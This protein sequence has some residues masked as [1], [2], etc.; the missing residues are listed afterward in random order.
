MQR[1][2]DLCKKILHTRDDTLSNFVIVE[3][4][5][6][7]AMA[8]VLEALA[9]YVQNMLTN[10]AKEE[11]HML[12]GVPYEMKKMD[13]KLRDLKSFLA[14]ADM[15][16]ISDETVQ[17]WVKEFR[18]AMYD[19][20]DILDLCQ[21]KSMKQGPSRDGIGCFDPLLF[22]L[23]NPLHAHDLG[24]RLRKLN[25]KLIDIEKRSKTFNFLPTS[26]EDNS[27][28][29]I[30]SSHLA[31]RETT[32]DLIK[33]DLVGHKVLEDTRNLVG[34]LT[35][36][37]EVIHEHN[38]V[39]IFAIVG[40]GGIGK[41]TLAKSIFN[42]EIIQQKF[43]K[44]IWLSVNQDFNDLDL[45]ERAI[46]GAGGNHHAARNTKDALVGILKEALKD[47]MTI[48]VMDDVWDHQAW[49]RVLKG[50]F[51]NALAPGSRVLVTTRHDTV[52]RG[53]KAEEPYHRVNKLHPDDAW[54]LLKKQ[55]RTSSFSYE[56]MFAS[57]SS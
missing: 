3:T 36:E 9:S 48:L 32:G 11:V 16:N 30:K 51:T 24:T 29:K 42:N 21:L 8:V 22:C 5:P 57:L 44:K 33:L 6:R 55:V 23:R 31:T 10:K 2:D 38:K 4:N 17:E 54:S 56:C 46:T 47:C 26:Y 53:M 19:A 1:P 25:E 27:I 34:L 49:E 15:R 12:L 37:E 50:P 13:V 45:L 40:V 20:S 41:T 14:D 28:R 52:A 39:M 7:P 43:N 35:R 18:G